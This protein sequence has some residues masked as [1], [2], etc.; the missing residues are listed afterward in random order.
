M[1]PIPF[2]D[3][4]DLPRLDHDQLPSLHGKQPP[5]VLVVGMH[6]SGTSMLT[7]ILHESGIF[8]GANMRHYESF[9]FSSFINDRLILG[10][11]DTW[12]QLPLMPVEEVLSYQQSIAPLIK[13][14]WLVDYL[15]WGYDGTSR[16]GVKDPRLCVLLPLYLKIFPQATVVHIRRDAND[17]AA[18]LTMKYK[19]G[20][21]ILTDF[22]HWKAL[23]HA[24]TKRVEEYALSCNL[25][26]QVQYEDFCRHPHQQAAELFN[27]LEL[28]FNSHTEQLLANV[29]ASRIGSYQR[30]LAA[31]ETPLL[32]KLTK[33]FQG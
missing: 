18:S 30:W 22:E 31:K 6:N 20:V 1:T 2:P 11:G 9:F 16:W 33:L 32:A 29:T 27:T 8:F 5:P 26:V 15:Q 17:V 28:P 3:P 24:Y 19:E 25:Y 10:G 7:R 4:Q 21:G 12:A 23:A 14:H 13:Q